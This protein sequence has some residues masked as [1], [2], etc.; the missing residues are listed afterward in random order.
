[1]IIALPPETE[2]LARRVAARS[3]KTL[4]D[5]LK[6]GVEMEARI[7]GIAVMEA[8]RRP[9]DIDRARDITRRISSRPLLDPRTPRDIL[10]EAWTDP[11]DRR[12][13]FGF[14]RHS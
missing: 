11:D 12:R 9:A 13:Q 7:A 10:E 8:S 1:V 4:E 6:A 3:G 14:H 5:V 2:Q